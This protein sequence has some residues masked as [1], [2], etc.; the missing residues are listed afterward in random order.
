MQKRAKI[1]YQYS[2]YATFMSDTLN[3]KFL[4]NK[5]DIAFWL[6]NHDIN[7]YEIVESPFYGFVVNVEGSVKLGARKLPC[8]AV[9]FERVTGDFFCELNSLTSLAGS[10]S[11]VGGDF[12]CSHNLILSLIDSP[13]H[14]GGDFWCSSNKIKSLEG[15][16]TKVGKSFLCI[17]NYLTSLAH[18]PQIISGTFDVSGNNIKSLVGGPR[19]VE[20][21]FLCTHNKLKNLE[22]CP[23]EMKDGNFRNNQIEN[24]VFFPAK[25]GKTINL[26]ANELGPRQ[27]IVDALHLYQEHLKDRALWEKSM[28]NSNIKM[29][30]NKPLDKI[31]VIKI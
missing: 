12:D 7:N 9:K 26:V 15:I 13:K 1:I 24:L 3:P 8:I 5:K 6:D 25:F 22:G 2:N 4:N 19:I 16:P 28:I 20:F 23:Q 10:P 18:S 11:Y 14:V 17:N 29:R 21:D 27:N 30:S 31:H